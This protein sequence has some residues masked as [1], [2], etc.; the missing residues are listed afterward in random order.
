MNEE[1]FVLGQTVWF[2]PDDHR[3][4]GFYSKIVKVGRIYYTIEKWNLKFDKE[5]LCRCEYPHGKLY[6][7]EQTARDYK[8][9]EKMLWDLTHRCR[10]KPS[11]EQMKAVYEILGIGDKKQ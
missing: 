4:K 11:L 7:S 6:S 1:R 9:A 10:K 2:E 5:I 3:D 8:I